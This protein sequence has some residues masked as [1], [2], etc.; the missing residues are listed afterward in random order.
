[1]A[2]PEVGVASAPAKFRELRRWPR[3]QIRV[4]VTVIVKKP[5]KTVYID[6][7]GTDL[8]EGGIAVFAGSE[9]GIGEEV[10]ISF[11]PPYHGE[12]LIARTII[13]NRRGYTYGMEFVT[14]TKIDEERVSRIRQVLR[15]LGSDVA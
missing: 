9:L 4:P 6:G 10:E 7:R 1:M 12:P 5:N 2:H 15:A 8:N 11:T 3:L 14:E 13:R